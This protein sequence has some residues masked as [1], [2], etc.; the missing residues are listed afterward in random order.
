MLELILLLLAGAAA[1]LAVMA[2]GRPS[3]MP[4]VERAIYRVL[5]VAAWLEDVGTALD[6]ALLRYR[7]ERKFVQIE[8]ESTRHREESS[9]AIGYAQTPAPGT[10]WFPE[11]EEIERN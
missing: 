6:A 11:R 5:A 8:L 2:I 10:I 9:A 1:L 7:I 4:L 3:P